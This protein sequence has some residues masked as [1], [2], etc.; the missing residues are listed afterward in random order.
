[1]S[2]R[3]QLVLLVAISLVA[4]LSVGAGVEGIHAGLAHATTDWLGG[5]DD[6]QRG[7]AR[8]GFRDDERFD[9]RFA[10]FLLE[11]LP[12]GEMTEE[13]WEGVRAL[14]DTVLSDGGQ[15]K[16]E[17]VMSLEDE[18][19]ARD[20]QSFFGSLFGRFVHG[21]DRYHVAVFGEPREDGAFGI[22]V[23]GHH[24]SINLTASEDRLVA[25]TPL[26]IGAEPRE[27]PEDWERGGL[28]VLAAEEDGGR[29]L[30]RS[31]SPEQRSQAVLELELASGPAGVNR[32]L[33][34]GEGERVEPGEPVGVAYADLAP[35]QQKQ[36]DGLI[37]LWIDN[38]EAPI[39]SGYRKAI[40]ADGRDTIR[41][42]FAGSGEPDTPTYYRIQGPGF[43]IE[44]D[45]TMEA[46]DHVH[47]VWRHFDG[48]FGRDL[49]AEHWY[50]EHR[51]AFALRSPPR[52]PDQ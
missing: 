43:L 4:L 7:E 29:A 13:Q 24:L 15:E 1:M 50:R 30:F 23:E 27:V 36:L 18:V 38:F 9:I 22:R 42:A 11:G 33:F 51:E 45:D 2:R 31:L 39:A 5:L 48:D 12:R 47:T 46:A 44:W 32:A 16:V 20:R 34:L 21:T 26:F 28:R 35:D 52:S 8:Y 3:S 40:D 25:V 6:S 19:L 41:F 17:A 49:L 14:L 10:P 37:D